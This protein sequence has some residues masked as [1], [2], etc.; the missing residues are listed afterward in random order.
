M[1]SKKQYLYEILFRFNKDG[2]Q[3]VHRID[4]VSVVDED[5][6]EVIAERQ[7]PAQP[8]DAGTA[9]KVMGEEMTVLADQVLQGQTM[10][11]MQDEALAAALER[12]AALQAYID[13]LHAVHAAELEE[14]HARLAREDPDPNP[15]LLPYVDPLP[16][17]GTP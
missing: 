1:I 11:A 13:T 4:A 8:L 17:R 9:R 12:E 2:L 10:M 3:G 14:L 15:V 6:G 7:L 5:S 16:L